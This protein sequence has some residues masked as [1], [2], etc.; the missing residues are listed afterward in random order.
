MR[1]PEGT[2]F[3]DHPHLA[4]QPARTSFKKTLTK[5]YIFCQKK[6]FGVY[7][8]WAGPLKHH[9][10]RYDATSWSWVLQLRIFLAAYFRQ[11]M[12]DP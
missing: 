1:Q 5:K 2:F 12:D 6:T 11:T 4:D 3:K 10:P 8:I 7:T 9:A